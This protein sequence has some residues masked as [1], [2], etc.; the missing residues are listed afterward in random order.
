MEFGTVS[1]MCKWIRN[2]CFWQHE[3]CRSFNLCWWEGFKGNKYGW[4]MPTL[5]S[6]YPPHFGKSHR[7][8]LENQSFL[9]F[10][11]S[12]PHLIFYIETISSWV[13]SYTLIQWPILVYSFQ[14]FLMQSIK[15]IM[16]DILVGSHTFSFTLI[17]GFLAS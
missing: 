17:L 1:N 8:W 5:A 15:Y 13:P 12:F 2:L 3:M 7:S 16:Y 11:F 4:Y 14:M 9:G 6:F 10:C